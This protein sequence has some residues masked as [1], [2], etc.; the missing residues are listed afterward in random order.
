MRLFRRSREQAL[1]WRSFPDVSCL[2]ARRHEPNLSTT[3]WPRTRILAGCPRPLSNDCAESARCRSS[4]RLPQDAEVRSKSTNSSPRASRRCTTATTTPPRVLT[5]R[6]TSVAARPRWACSGWTTAR[7]ARRSP[8]LLAPSSRPVTASVLIR[9]GSLPTRIRSFFLR[10]GDGPPYVIT[11]NLAQHLASWQKR[12]HEPC[13][14]RGRLE[15]DRGA[16]AD[17]VA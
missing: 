5:P 9:R 6:A 3:R 14:T 16:I 1:S 12:R 4:P 2:G 8:S 13:D 15:S 7:S 17:G 11:K 10:P